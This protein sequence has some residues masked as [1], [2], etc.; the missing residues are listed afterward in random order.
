MQTGTWLD[1][2]SYTMTNLVQNP[3]TPYNHGSELWGV[4][5]DG[6]YYGTNLWYIIPVG[7]MF[8]GTPSRIEWWTLDDQLRVVQDGYDAD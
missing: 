4:L 7:D 8:V 3:Y 2:P 1:P 6:T 5:W